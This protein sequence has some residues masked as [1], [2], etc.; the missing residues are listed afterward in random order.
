MPC[1]LIPVCVQGGC[2]CICE[3][4]CGALI[5]NKPQKR[6]LF[7]KSLHRISINLLTIYTPGMLIT[8]LLHSPNSFAKI[9][10]QKQALY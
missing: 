6:G 8:M 1:L 4:V 5:T 3:C 2:A 10:E 7:C 9:R